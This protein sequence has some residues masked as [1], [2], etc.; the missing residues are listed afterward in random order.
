MFFARTAHP[1]FRF[2][3]PVR[4]ELGIRT[5]M[6]C[7]GPLLNP[8]G[9]PHQIV[10]VYTSALVDPLARALEGLGARRALVVHGCDGMDEITTT[11]PSRACMVGDGEPRSF[12]IEP[13]ELGIARAGS[14]DLR[15]SD[16]DTNAKILREI[17][18][19]EEGPRRDIVLL[20]AGAALWVVGVAESHAEGIER[21]RESIDSGA[22]E[23]KLSALVRATQARAQESTRAGI[24]TRALS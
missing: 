10:G 4:Q 21:A 22:A 8:A 20:N 11:G 18:A 13:E 5:L 15:G 9:A 17:L 1:A 14:S 16:P 7:L 24:S 23:A 19:G 3:A 6:N 12:E 2:V